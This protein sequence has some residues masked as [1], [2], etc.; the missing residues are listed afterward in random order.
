MHKSS[1]SIAELK[2]QKLSKR[3]TVLLIFPVIKDMKKIINCSNL[4]SFR[5]VNDYEVGFGQ[6]T[7][8]T[9]Y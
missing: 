6:K 3:H 4:N 1:V 2:T 5:I 8:F 9:T 7:N